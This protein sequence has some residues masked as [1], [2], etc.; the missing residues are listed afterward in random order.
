MASALHITELLAAEEGEPGWYAALGVGYSDAGVKASFWLDSDRSSGSVDTGGLAGQAY[1]GY[2]FSPHRAIEA[3]FLYA[4]KTEFHGET[5]GFNSRWNAG[6]MFGRTRIDGLHIG[7]VGRWP[8]GDSGYALYAK[9]GLLFWDTTTYYKST[10]NDINHFNSDGVS[11]ML[12]L[13]MDMNLWREWRLR[14]EYLYST[15]N[16]ERRVSVDVNML[17]VSMVHSF[18]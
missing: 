12:A 17:T 5:D 13:G 10:I 1:V 8:V 3:G 11:P 9:G 2:R 14:A 6:R 15:V 4:G 18:P 7:A 16:L